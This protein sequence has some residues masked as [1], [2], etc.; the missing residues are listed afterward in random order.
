[1]STLYQLH[2]VHP[3]VFPTAHVLFVTQTKQKGKHI[4]I[5]DRVKQGIPG[6]IMY[7]ALLTPEIIV[8][9][10]SIEF[11]L[12]TK[13]RF[14]DT[15]KL[16]ERINWQL[17]IMKGMDP[18]R[19]YNANPLFAKGK[20]D[21]LIKI[22]KDW[23]ISTDLVATGKDGKGRFRGRLDTRP[24]ELYEK[25]GFKYMYSVELDHTA[26]RASEF[27]DAPVCDMSVFS[28]GAV[29]IPKSKHNI[30]NPDWLLWNTI[31]NKQLDGSGVFCFHIK[32]SDADTHHDAKIGPKDVKN[33]ILAFHPL[34]HHEKLDYANLAHMGDIHVTSRQQFLAGS[35]AKVI[36]A[37][38]QPTVGSLV[39]TCSQRVKTLF[40]SFGGDKNVHAIIIGGDFGDYIRSMYTKDL[41][42]KEGNRQP[43]SV[44]RIWE[45]THVEKG[46]MPNYTDFPDFITVF[47]FV[48]ASYRS[49]HKPIFAITGN[50]DAYSF[51]FGVSPRPFRDGE[52]SKKGNE[53][54]PADHNMTIYEC[55]LSQGPTFGKVVTDPAISDPLNCMLL[56]RR[57][58][59][60]YTAFTP[61]ADFA[62]WL[63][64]QI[65][66]AMSWGDG[67]NM[68]S[69]TNLEQGIGHLPRAIKGVS[70]DQLAM[71]KGV[72]ADNTDSAEGGRRN[73]ILTT[74]F[75]F[76]SFGEA[77]PENDA[78]ASTW[79]D[80]DA[81]HIFY[82]KGS[83]PGS[84]VYSHFD[85]GTFELNREEMY[86]K[87]ILDG[88]TSGKAAIQVI[89]TGHSH[90]RAT[91][92]FRQAH[93]PQFGSDSVLTDYSDFPASFAPG[94]D[95]RLL[96][97]AGNER[98]EP[99]V[100]LSDSGGPVPRMN[101]HGEFRGWGSDQPAGTKITFAP[102][103]KLD[104]IE[105]IR[106]GLK[107]RF[108]VSMDYFDIIVLRTG[109]NS[110]TDFKD[111]VAIKSWISD[112]TPLDSAGSMTGKSLNFTLR[113]NPEFGRKFDKHMS[114][115]YAPA[116]KGQLI[117]AGIKIESISLFFTPG[118]GGSKPDHSTIEANAKE[119]KLTPTT[120]TELVML[121]SKWQ[122]TSAADLR[123]L[124]NYFES[125]TK[126]R[127][128]AS[129]KFKAD[130][131]SWWS[132]VY[133][134]DT[135]WNFEIGIS[136]DFKK[137]FPLFG[138]KTAKIYEIERQ[139]VEIPSFDERLEMFKYAGL[140]AV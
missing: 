84:S 120:T 117:Y 1:M 31:V 129:I 55:I 83:T 50:H 6:A 46:N 35:A 81:G 71:L 132:R 85:F 94:S 4:N 115:E 138:T 49:S 130:P 91:Y 9:K 88:R 123:M 86:K 20:L 109:G 67:E 13:E 122:I 24:V 131:N 43:L 26:I 134:F 96:D 12:L 42:D 79:G 41:H 29:V 110:F 93:V 18:K 97:P 77:I 78:R 11:L 33:P 137:S 68:V 51:P 40:D 27:K 82:K 62:V 48:V 66:V 53:G 99:W 139:N 73:V 103:G 92:T 17:K 32:K 30:D 105:P 47:T 58:L 60:F 8:G 90:R 124:A 5:I 52:A 16:R 101:K 59:W 114:D 44:Q 116:G 57:F 64:K 119:I 98:R 36:H 100:I 133:D 45:L 125:T 136:V 39:N 10:Q 22:H 108:A 112:P 74:H 69:P 95:P 3:I 56:P 54:I 102:D 140:G 111:D 128:F 80:E 19:E 87:I 72:I 63:P 104:K 113:L 75:T 7:P 70:D 76:A 135:A 23:N 14:S 61:W 126:R 118:G 65:I 28:N 121:S 37:P 2:W 107:P 38:G 34:I 21:D 106:T 25:N 127:T 89:L 15:N